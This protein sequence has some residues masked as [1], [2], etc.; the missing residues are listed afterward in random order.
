MKPRVKASE[1]KLAS[2]RK[3]LCNNFLSQVEFYFSYDFYFSNTSYSRLISETFDQDRYAIGDQPVKVERYQRR[4]INKLQQ[5][6]STA[7][8]AQNFFN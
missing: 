5:P 1:Q 4:P 6:F 7:I 2:E 8:D 3:L